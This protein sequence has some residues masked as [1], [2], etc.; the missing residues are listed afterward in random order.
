MPNYSRQQRNEWAAR[1]RERNREYGVWY[2]MI[3]RCHNPAASGYKNYGGRGITVAAAWSGKNGY[4]RFLADMGKR[5]SP[6][7][8]IERLDNSGGYSRNNCEWATRKKQNR[9][10]RNNVPISHSGETMVMADWADAKGIPRLTLRRRI[11][12][13]GWN[14]EEALDTSV[15]SVH[16]RPGQKRA[17]I[18]IT[19]NGKT[20]PIKAWAAELGVTANAVYQRIKRGLPMTS[21]FGSSDLQRES[22]VRRN[23]EAALV[24]EFRGESLTLEEWS[25][26][27]GVPKSK[28]WFRLR[29]YGWPIARALGTP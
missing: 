6:T 2:A 8:T 22:V 4:R 27:S 23:K 18:F 12:D 29:R 11:R 28:L 26:R 20:A 3:D 21:V 14:P 24:F 13:L 25:I 15:G 9:N 16:K 7:H 5:P 19:H 17:P 1:W 10:K